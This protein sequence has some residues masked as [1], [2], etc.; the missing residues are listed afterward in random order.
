MVDLLL[1]GPMQSRERAC[2]CIDGELCPVWGPL[3]EDVLPSV[4]NIRPRG[5]CQLAAAL[6]NRILFRR[7]FNMMPDSQ[8]RQRRTQSWDRGSSLTVNPASST[9]H[10]VIEKRT[11]FVFVWMRPFV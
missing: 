1:L 6:S 7:F 11:R 9:N 2:R 3:L 10:H 5:G 8:P 4:V